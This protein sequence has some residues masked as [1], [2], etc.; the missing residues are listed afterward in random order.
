MVNIAVI[1]PPECGKSTFIRK[2]V[3]NLHPQALPPIRRRGYSSKTLIY[4][5]LLLYRFRISD[6]SFASFASS[7]V[8]VACTLAALD[9]PPGLETTRIL[10]I[11]SAILSSDALWL[12]GWPRL[13]GVILCYDASNLESF[14]RIPE[15]VGGY[16]TPS[17]GLF[18]ARSSY[19]LLTRIAISEG[20]HEL[21]LPM[22]VVA[23]KAESTVISSESVA[24][25]LDPFHVGLVEATATTEKGKN[26]MRMALAWTIQVSRLM[27]RKRACPHESLRPSFGD[28][29]A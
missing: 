27:E 3:K 23:C 5:S 12:E 21:P 7:N 8:I 17:G 20:Y 26:R 16:N 19:R 6:L 1:G 9:P 24:D 10:E 14:K 2:A 28:E 22:I 11:N 29:E 25:V 15:L 4:I 13:D 18:R